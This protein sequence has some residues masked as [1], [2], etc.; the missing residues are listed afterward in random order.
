MR[1]SV[2]A[3]I[4][5]LRRVL[6]ELTMSRSDLEMQIEGLKEEL[7][8][9]KKNHAE[10]LLSMRAQMSGQVNVEVDA[11]PGLDLCKIIDDVREQYEA[12]NAK[13]HKELEVWFQSKVRGEP[14]RVS[15]AIMG[16]MEV[17]RSVLCVLHA[18]GS[19]EQ[20]SHHQ[21]R[22]HPDV[23][24]RAQRPEAVPAEPGDRAAVPAQHGERLPSSRPPRGAN[25]TF[26]PHVQ[27]GALTQPSLLTSSRGR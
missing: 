5:G 4:A 20:R 22:G 11:A 8:F 26:S 10:E 14:P 19:P 7:I 1:Q 25:P 15:A 18:V 6:D 13:S 23:Q 24:N 12:A 2:E 21:H 9:L 17:T 16:W 3:D 27:Q